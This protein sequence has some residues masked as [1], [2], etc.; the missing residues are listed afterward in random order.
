MS[1]GVGTD[2]FETAA[3][4]GL[5]AED[6]GAPHCAPAEG[7]VTCGDVAQP[8]AVF[9]VDVERGLALCHDDRGRRETVEIALVLP[10]EPG[11]H[12]LV[13]AGTAISKLDAV[14]PVPGT[15]GREAEEV[16]EV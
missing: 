8:L 16:P 2:S 13:H 14:P 10:V 11:D 9:A 6:A 15:P 1:D 3:H 7:C 5:V 4:S 12:L